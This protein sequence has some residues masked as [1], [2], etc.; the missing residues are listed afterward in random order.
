MPQV[1]PPVQALDHLKIFHEKCERW[2]EVTGF[3]IGQ[4]ARHVTFKAACHH[5]QMTF[6][7]SVRKQEVM[8]P[9]SNHESREASLS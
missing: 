8:L 9:R 1:K 3:Q 7:F 4:G 6:K 5:C 2:S